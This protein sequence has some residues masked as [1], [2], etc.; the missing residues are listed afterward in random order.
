GGPQTER[1]DLSNADT[2]QD[3]VTRLE[4]PFA[5]DLTVGITATGITLTPSA[6]TVAVA[7][8]PNSRVAGDLGIKS[9]AGASITS[10]D[11]DPRLSRLTTLA[12]LNG[13]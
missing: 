7:D 1:I 4:A 9:A 12:S 10:K 2:I 6:G 5:G 8:L 3:F 11:L 13:G